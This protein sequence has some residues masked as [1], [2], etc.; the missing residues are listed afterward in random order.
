MLALWLGVGLTR[1]KGELHLLIIKFPACLGVLWRC[2]PAHSAGLFA[3][4]LTRTCK[5]TSSEQLWP[6]VL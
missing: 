1:E 2:Q 4:L 3:L 5:K 6:S